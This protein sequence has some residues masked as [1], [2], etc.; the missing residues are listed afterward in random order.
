MDKAQEVIDQWPTFASAYDLDSDVGILIKPDYKITSFN[1]SQ[2]QDL[3]AKL[4]TLT[5]T[6][7]LKN[8][9]ETFP[10]L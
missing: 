8:F 10:E 6:E 9:F 5:Q 1:F 2:L 3:I 4:K 7:D